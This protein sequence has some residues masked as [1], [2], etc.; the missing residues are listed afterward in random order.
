MRA[1]LPSTQPRSVRNAPTAYAMAT[2]TV[3][4][5]ARSRGSNGAIAS[6]SH[7]GNGAGAARSG[8]K[9]GEP[10]APLQRPTPGRQGEVPGLAQNSVFSGSMPRIWW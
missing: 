7:G 3:P 9:A 10:R 5:R 2:G 1:V 8:A 6:R 4:S